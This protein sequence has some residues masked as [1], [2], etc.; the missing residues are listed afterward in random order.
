[1]AVIDSIRR[2][3]GLSPKYETTAYGPLKKAVLAA[4]KRDG[5]KVGYGAGYP[6]VELHSFTE[7]ARLDKEGQLREMTFTVEAISDRSE[8]ECSMLNEDNLRILTSAELNLG[9]DWQCIRI[10]PEQLQDQT[11]VSDTDSV[12]YRLL[13]SYRLFI[14]QIKS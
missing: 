7:G 12:L 11:E 3:F 1:M 6:R 5:V 9:N 2:F 13:Q 4:L 14:L 10:I 8:T